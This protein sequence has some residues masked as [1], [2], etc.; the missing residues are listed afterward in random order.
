VAAV[1]EALDQAR[2]AVILS[3]LGAPSA[4]GLADVT[5]QILESWTVPRPRSVI[6][7][8]GVIIHTNLGRAPLSDAAISAME[9]TARDYCDLEYELESGERGSRHSHPVAL[10]R[11]L[12]GAQDALVVNNNAGA[13]LLILSALAGGREVI[14]SRGQLVE[15]GGGFRIPDVMQAG[16]ARLVEVGTTNRTYVNDYA[17]KCGPDTSLLLRVHTSNYRMVGFVREVSL[18]E[19]VQL[20]RERDLPVVDDLGSG[21]LL[22]TAQFGLAA[23]PRVQ[24]SVRAGASLVTFSGDKL[25][26]GPQAG[27]IVGREDLVG[28]LREHPLARALR[29]DK[30]A[31]AGLHATLLHYAKGEALGEVPV[32]RMIA[33]PASELRSR[34]EA[35]RSEVEAAGYAA[36]VVD[37]L[38]AVGGGSLPGET[39][40]TALLSIEVP[41]PHELADALR[42]GQPPIVARVQDERLVLDPRTVLAQPGVVESALVTALQRYRDERAAPPDV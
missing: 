24:D 42:C 2:Q 20:G 5:A 37:G 38:S 25:L 10:L 23:E 8:T 22:D 29:P 41:Q 35:W 13:T 1:R 27:I 28:R 12:T 34:A 14:V 6:N 26:G 7:A 17:E 18:A 3:E 31:L 36:Q 4:A 32:W 39:L 11:R 9:A 33:V 19:L 40:P 15:I 16:G 21:S 30:V